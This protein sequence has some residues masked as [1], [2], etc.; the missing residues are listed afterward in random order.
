MFALYNIPSSE[1][2]KDMDEFHLNCLPFIAPQRSEVD[3]QVN[4]RDVK[5]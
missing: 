5:D 3:G 4:I 2:L 1:K